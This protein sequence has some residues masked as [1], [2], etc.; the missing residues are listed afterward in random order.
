MGLVSFAT[1][2]DGLVLKSTPRIPMPDNRR[3]G[4]LTG[5]SAFSLT[6]LVVIIAV[7]AILATVM[8][9]GVARTR[10]NTRAIQCLNNHRQLLT[11]WKMYAGDNSDKVIYNTGVQETVA[12][13]TNQTYR[14]WANNI[15]SWD[16]NPMNTNQLLLA[17]GLFAPYLAGSA[18][19]YRCP[20]DNYASPAQATL[21]WGGRT[22]SVSMNGFFGPY[23]TNLNDVTYKGKNEFE[24]NYQQW[25]KIA[26][27][28]SPAGYWLFIDEHPDS[29]NDGYFINNL[30]GA[31]AWGD[32][33]TSFHNS[34]ASISYVDGHAEVH[35]WMSTVTT[36]PVRY[37]YFSAAFDSLGRADF[38]WLVART[39]VLH[40]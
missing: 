12:E 34:G 10:V 13:V 37:S 30:T 11:A 8:T 29:I 32:I 26:E 36:Q 20:A 3:P 39:A 2:I 25:L 17:S 15:M 40:K 18:L 1:D 22:R 33:P 23:T 24:Q 38:Q 35:K 6:E 14:E 28:P 21:G 27:V 4:F 16:T 7:V 19:P 5:R 9:P 31:P